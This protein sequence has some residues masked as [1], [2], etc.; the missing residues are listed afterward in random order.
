MICHPIW[1]MLVQ[2]QNWMEE[3]YIRESSNRQVLIEKD[4]YFWWIYL[5]SPRLCHSHW[6]LLVAI[7]T[8]S[9]ILILSFSSREPQNNRLLMHITNSTD[10]MSEDIWWIDSVSEC[11]PKWKLVEW[12]FIIQWQWLRWKRV[13][14]H[15]PQ[16]WRACIRVVRWANANNIVAWCQTPIGKQIKSKS[17]RWRWW[18]HQRL[19][20]NSMTKAMVEQ[21]QPGEKK[22]ILSLLFILTA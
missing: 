14:Q 8:H 7:A 11:E 9:R 1:R 19:H 13:Q 5:S 21:Q 12:K 6:A 17:L 10:C 3:T 16:S 20:F 15:P 4:E 2:L 18:V 22:K